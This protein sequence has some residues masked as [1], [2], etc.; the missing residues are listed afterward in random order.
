MKKISLKI[1]EIYQLERELVGTKIM[2]GEE[3][4]TSSLLY[5]YKFSFITKFWLNELYKN[6][7]DIKNSVE[8]IKNS[9]IIK[10]GECCNN[11]EFSINLYLEDGSTNPH[12][13]EFNREWVKLMEQEKEIEYKPFKLEEFSNIKIEGY[14][15]VFF[16]LIEI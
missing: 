13:L 4:I 11:E 15:S 7:I 9:F 1:R 16:K 5:D 12:Y 2:N 10:Y 14:F 8:D 3:K 6:I